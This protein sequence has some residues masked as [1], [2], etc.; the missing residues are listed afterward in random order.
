[1]ASNRLN[2]LSTSL[3]SAGLDALVLN[4]SPSLNYLT[5]LQFHLMERPIVG[6][7]LPEASPSLVLPELEVS[8][9][10]SVPGPIQTFA[11]GENP[12]TWREAFIAAAQAL[13]LDGKTI[14]VEPNHLRYLELR[15]LEE[16][17]PRSRFVS[18]ADT[19]TSLRIQK[20]PEEIALIRQAVNIAQQAFNATLP[21]IKIGMTE[22]QLASEL[23]SQLLRAG[24]DPQ[25]PFF[26]II[27]SGPNSAN[28]H[29]TST[30]R[31]LQAG[32]LVVIDWGA[33]VKGYCSDLTRT[34]G[35]K[36]VRQE[37]AYIAEVVALANATGRAAG[38]PGVPAGQVDRV[39]REVIDENEYGEYFMHRTGHGLGMEEHEEPYLY[40]DN[41]LP[42]APGMVYTV[43]P[44]I[45]IPGLGGVRIEDDVVVT[46]GGSESLSNL[47]RDLI[48]V[49]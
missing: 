33:A 2:R 14:G 40:G 35:V 28:P 44:G 30:D 48:I 12:A 27:A 9:A 42:L 21:L 26:P 47:V 13:H 36:E 43:E 24:S 45:Y 3:Q 1:M 15:L 7:F 11:Y 46:P 25:V 41:P 5:G 23:T 37:L 38:K 39:T 22:R 8:K 32:D 4:P 20:D 31:P 17:M 29:A 18:A 16:A 10:Q 6:L 49:G 19:L 34:I